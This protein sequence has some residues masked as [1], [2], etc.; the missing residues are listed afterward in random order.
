[1]TIQDLILNGQLRCVDCSKVL[2][3]FSDPNYI[4]C[5]CGKKYTVVNEMIF[6]FPEVSDETTNGFVAKT[7]ARPSMYRKLIDMKWKTMGVLGLH[8]KMLGISELVS[9]KSILELGCGPDLDLPSTELDLGLLKSY[10]G[11]DFSSSFIDSARAKNQGSSF[12]FIQADAGNLPFEDD[13]FDVVIA[14]FTIH[15]VPHDPQQVVDEM[16]RVA[17][18]TVIIFDH[19][20]SDSAFVGRLQLLYWRVIDGGY[21]YQTEQQWSRSLRDR[22]PIASLRTGALGKHVTKMV[23]PK[24]LPA[25]ISQTTS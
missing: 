18:H 8:D 25:V 4:A 5:S 12:D 1:M 15:H 9:N 23:F 17:R 16:F 19:I 14:A 24:V 21:H 2:E 11:L 20:Q 6:T 22:T 13:S 10:V 7:F 3:H